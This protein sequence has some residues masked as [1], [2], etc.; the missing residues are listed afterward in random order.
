MHE[1]SLMKNVIDATLNQ[2]KDNPLKSGEIIK[3]VSF[4]IGALDIHSKESFRQAFGNL[5]KDTPLSNAKLELEIV[6]GHLKC[7]DCGYDAP[8]PTEKGD[9][10]ETIPVTEC[11]GC[12]LLIPIQGGRGIADIRLEANEAADKA[13]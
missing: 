12:K 7:G 11:P 5:I 6:P 2:L 4:K 9:G 10:H 8:C 3:K 1:Y 13:K